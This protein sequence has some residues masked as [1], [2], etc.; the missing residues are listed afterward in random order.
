MQL[1]AFSRMEVTLADHELS[2]GKGS[3]KAE[4]FESVVKI[5]RQGL[6]GGEVWDPTTILSAGN[7]MTFADGEFKVIKLGESNVRHVYVK[8]G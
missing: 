1:D 6:P 4:N 5:I 3:G 2:L 8:V 7:E